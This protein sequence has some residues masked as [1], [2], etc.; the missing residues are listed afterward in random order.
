[1]GPQHRYTGPTTHWQSSRGV[2]T[3]D[4]VGRVPAA[5]F[6]P[7]Q[8]EAAAPVARLPRLLAPK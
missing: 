4:G 3:S 8:T 7:S 2:V 1:M 6:V 5:A